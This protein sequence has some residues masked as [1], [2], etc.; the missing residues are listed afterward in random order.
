MKSKKLIIGIATVAVCSTM[1]FGGCTND[2]ISN[3][4][5]PLTISSEALDGVF[6]PFF[7]T[8]GADGEIVGQTQI[9][10]LTTDKDG[11]VVS[12]EDYACVA[13]AHSFETVGSED[14]YNSTGSYDDYYTDYWFAIK[15]GVKY[16]D[17]E[18]LTIKDV[19]FNLYVLLDPAY[20]GSSTLYSTE[21]QGL[22]AY[23]AQSYDENE[24]ANADA[25]YTELAKLRIAY[26]TEWCDDKDTTYQDLERL[27]ETIEASEGYSLLTYIDKAKELFKE[28][29][30]S[31]WSTASTYLEDNDYT[32]YGFSQTWEIFL[33]MEGFITVSTE[34]NVKDTPAA[35]QWNGY[36]KLSA[37]EKTQEYLVQHVY[38]NYINYPDE[39]SSLDTYKTNLKAITTGGWATADSF[40]TYVK[41][42]VIRDEIEKNGMTVPN[43]SGI[44]TERANHIGLEGTSSYQ[45]LDGEYD[46]LKIRVNGVDPKA[47]Y[48]F[49]FTVA[50]MHYYSSLADKFNIAENNFGVSFS[51]SE[52][53]DSMRS[54]QVPVGAGPYKATNSATNANGAPAKSDFFTDNIVYFERNE[55]FET[56]GEGLSNAKIKKLRYKVIAS[57]QLYDAITGNSTEVLYGA[58]TAKQTY[59]S[60]LAGLKVEGKFDYA[61]AD[62]LGYGYIGINAGKIPDVRIRR[63]IMYAMDTTLCLDYYGDQSLASILYRPMSSTIAWAYPAGSPA[64]YPYDKTGATSLAL[65][66][67]A[68]YSLSPTT[69]KLTNSK[70]ETLKFTFTIAGDSSDHPAYTVM[71]NAAD[72]LN[73]QGFD[74]TVTT[75]SNA[76]RKLANGNLSVWAA[77]WSSTIDPDMYQVYHK[78]SNA[79]STKNWGYDEIYDDDNDALYA[80]SYDCAFG[81]VPY[82]Q[83]GLV[84]VLSEYIMDARKTTNQTTRAAI[85]SDCLDMV[86]ELAVELPTYQR[87]N[88]FVWNTTYID[89]S[90]LVEATAYQSPLGEIWNVSFNVK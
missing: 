50:P 24:Q 15:K 45:T 78:D 10:M 90:T 55:Y 30:N 59:T 73:K 37:S 85:Y 35:V 9:G 31:D 66:Q 20:T 76:L 4:T 87:K 46:I 1:L 29:L 51:D 62:N 56:V 72:I 11:N 82:T 27:S 33:Y 60:Q 63:A 64:Y 65:A 67:E 53:F 44:T 89:S 43:V 52:F 34:D 21:I 39:L 18:E 2:G 80:T 38:D 12:G 42:R 86:M 40:L 13:A 54:I 74:I 14:S 68:G 6:N 71:Q 48:N 7:Y 19:L 25:T 47:I 16:S 17:G 8:S 36:D 84:D 32:K 23:R 69:R 3:E 75:D 41:S 88:M 83:R 49:S 61:L 57:T 5:T 81:E 58:P 79:S 28:E 22:A 77:A 70:G 26:I